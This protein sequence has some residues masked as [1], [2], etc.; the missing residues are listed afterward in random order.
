MIT[1][2]YKFSLNSW[3]KKMSKD[4]LELEEKPKTY[5]TTNT[6]WKT[7]IRKSDIGKVTEY[8]EVQLLEDDERKAREL[9]CEK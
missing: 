4:V 3:D 8:D 9:F 5:M 1:K 2:L 6:T 7:R